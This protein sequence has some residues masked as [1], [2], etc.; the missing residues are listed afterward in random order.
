MLVFLISH[1][2]ELN[3][4]VRDDSSRHNGFTAG[5]RTLRYSRHGNKDHNIMQ[6]DSSF[7]FL[8]I[9]TIFLTYLCI[10]VEKIPECQSFCTFFCIKQNKYKKSQPFV[11]NRY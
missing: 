11:S 10:Y 9:M 6:S 1:L 3:G 8:Y 2:Q 5:R 4:A 7:F